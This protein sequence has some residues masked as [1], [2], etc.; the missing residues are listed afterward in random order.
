[1]KFILL[2]LDLV[3]RLSSYIVFPASVK[4]C[5]TCESKKQLKSLDGPNIPKCCSSNKGMLFKQVPKNPSNTDGV[6]FT[7][8]FHRASFRFCWASW[9]GKKV[10]IIKSLIQH[11]NLQTR[12]IITPLQ[13]PTYFLHP[14][15]SLQIQIWKV[16]SSHNLKLGAPRSVEEKRIKLA[17]HASW[18]RP[19]A[20]SQQL[21]GGN[22][23]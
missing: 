12:G 11:Q 21:R 10:K 18:Q 1:M 23:G 5:E 20:A 8:F 16:G 22:H 13:K 4:P 17:G 9:N 15:G 7:I 19:Q 2:L 3:S 14:L 6:K